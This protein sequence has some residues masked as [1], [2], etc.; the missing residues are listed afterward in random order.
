[1]TAELYDQDAPDVEEFLCRW[2][3]ALLRTAT[4][5]STDDPMPFCVVTRIDGAD[6]TNSGVDEPVVQLDIYDRARN[7]LL[8]AQAAKQT[9]NAVHRRMN[10]LARHLDSVTMSDGTIASALDVT[11]VIKPFRM[12]YADDKVVRYVARYRVGLSYVAV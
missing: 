12:P 11:T 2:L 5:R 10:L 9:A 3:A 4:E 7:S 1:M 6:D 8:A